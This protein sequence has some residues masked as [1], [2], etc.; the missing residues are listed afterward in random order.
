MHGLNLD[1]WLSELLGGRGSRG[2][3][4]ACQHRN[5][6]E[7]MSIHDGEKLKTVYCFINRNYGIINHLPHQSISQ[8][9]LNLEDIGK[10]VARFCKEINF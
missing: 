3:H 8:S 1:E 7:M 9:I 10:V 2:Q 6:Y 5:I 4:S